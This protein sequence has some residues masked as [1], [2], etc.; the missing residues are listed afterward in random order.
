M[1]LSDLLGLYTRREETLEKVKNAKIEDGLK[2][3]A[4]GGVVQ[5]VLGAAIMFMILMP[6]AALAPF[7]AAMAVGSAVGVLIGGILT[8]IIGA[9]IG[10]VIIW[11]L[12]AIQN[13][14]EDLVGLIGPI[15]YIEG[16]VALVSWLG[17]IPLIG[18]LINLAVAIYALYLIYLLLNKRGVPEDKAKITVIVLVVI[19]LVLTGLATMMGAMTAMSKPTVTY[20]Y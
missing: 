17:Y 12:L 6:L 16:A 20:P 9:V 4:V 8:P 19:A 10:A 7:G 14:K 1:C 5:G 11:I 2:A 15:G 13:H 18:W 3:A